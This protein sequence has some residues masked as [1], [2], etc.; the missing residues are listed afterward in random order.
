MQLNFSLDPVQ[1][2]LRRVVADPFLDV[3]E[4]AI[5]PGAA[6]QYNIEILYVVSG[7]LEISNGAIDL[8]L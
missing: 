7:I 8:V 1:A 2:R 4:T 5:A 6:Q 3:G